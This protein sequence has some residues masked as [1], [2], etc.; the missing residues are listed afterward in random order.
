MWDIKRKATNEQARKTS[1]NSQ[2][3]PIAWRL[4]EGK[5]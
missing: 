5:G 4:P 3:Q 1:K 2:T